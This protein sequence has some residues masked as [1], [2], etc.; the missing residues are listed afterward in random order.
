MPGASPAHR[1]RNNRLKLRASSRLPGW[2]QLAQVYSIAVLII[3]SWTI[4]WFFWK[5][6]TWQIFLTTGEILRV[7]AFS[8]ATN[9]VESLVL[10]CIPVL[11]ALILPRTWFSDVFVARGAS[12][13]MTGLA[14]LMF[15]GDQ[16]KFQ[17]AFPSTALEPWLLALPLG[18]L[19]LIVYLVGKIALFR[20]MVESLA[21][22]ATIFLFVMPPLSVISLLVVLVGLTT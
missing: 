8:L 4:L 9:M 17:G 3:Y 5:L 6:P 15:L 21:D 10:L 11:L 12:L 19:A 18:A 1:Q 20:R 16:L 14:Y 7:L 2:L 22:R 13:T